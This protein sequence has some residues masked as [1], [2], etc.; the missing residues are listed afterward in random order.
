MSFAD[1]VIKDLTEIPDSQEDS[2][3]RK[4]V[5]KELIGKKQGKEGEIEWPLSDSRD[6]TQLIKDL[7]NKG[8]NFRDEDR[9]RYYRTEYRRWK[10]LIIYVIVAAERII[11][12]K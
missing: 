10:S 12:N 3:D 1:T 11:E 2:G 5:N 7:I 4:E 6:A 9:M 8:R